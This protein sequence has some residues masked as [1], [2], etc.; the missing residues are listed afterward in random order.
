MGA[1]IDGATEK[2][3]KATAHPSCEAD[4]QLNDIQICNNNGQLNFQLETA[5]K[6]EVTTGSN[7]IPE[8]KILRDEGYVPN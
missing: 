4:T 1:K 3:K 7:A 5:L 6:N 8:D 2:L